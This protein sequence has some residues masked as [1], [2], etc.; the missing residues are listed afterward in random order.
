MIP[1]SMRCREKEGDSSR[2][3]NYATFLPFPGNSVSSRYAKSE[4]RPPERANSA[5]IGDQPQRFPGSDSR[6]A[7]D[8]PA[9]CQ[10][11]PVACIRVPTRI[12][13]LVPCYAAVTRLPEYRWRT[14]QRKFSTREFLL[15][16]KYD[17]RD[18]AGRI[19]LS[20]ILRFHIRA[21]TRMRSRRKE[22]CLCSAS[23]TPRL[24]R[25]RIRRESRRRSGR[26]RTV[27]RSQRC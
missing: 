25:S 24:Q 7:R 4:C 14:P 26:K 22:Q 1:W 9:N 8:G 15:V 2:M 16:G 19:L 18:V 17:R 20:K 13:T 10:A 6:C 11:C 27:L 21:A 12:N 3:S 5:A 23:M